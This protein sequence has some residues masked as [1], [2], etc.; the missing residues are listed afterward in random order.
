MHCHAG[1]L[2]G[3]TRYGWFIYASEEPAPP[4]PD[5]LIDVF[6]H[7]RRHGCEYVLFDCDAPFIDGVPVRHP[8][9]SGS[10]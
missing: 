2:G 10:A 5:D 9:F 6:H 8:D 7:A 3:A 1:I 4:I